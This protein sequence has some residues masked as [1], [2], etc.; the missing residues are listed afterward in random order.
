MAITKHV[1]LLCRGVGAWNAARA[2]EPF[3][4]DLTHLDIR[5][6]DLREIDFS[7]ADFDGTRMSNVDLRGARLLDAKLNGVRITSAHFG[8]AALDRVELKGADFTRVSFAGAVLDHAVGLDLKVR[9]GDLAGARIRAARLEMTHLYNCDLGG[10]DFAGSALPGSLLKRV[11]M[12][13]AVRAQVEQAGCRIDLGNA[14]RREEWVDWNAFDVRASEAE[15]GV[16]VCAGRAYWIAEG[17][18]DFFISHASE[19]KDSVAR[20]LAQALR[21]IGQRVWFDELTIK[22]GDALDEVIA[23][24][25]RASV[26]GIAVVSPRFFGR[27]WTEAELAAL[28]GKRM[29]LVLTD[30]DAGELAKLRP[31]LANRLCL[32]AELGPKAVAESLVEASRRPE[33]EI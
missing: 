32:R 13:D 17:R 8:G 29:F 9:H 27:R 23:Q 15:F 25:T 14:P 4:P 28:E 16:I 10:A 19:D 6:A 24:G 3:V 22:A 26:F 2:D 7:G 11:A 21:A 30:M 18:W 31:S 20:P 33:R 1:E 5:N 12:D